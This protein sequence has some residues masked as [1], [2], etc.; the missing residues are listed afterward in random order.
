M[1]ETLD[2]QTSK[3]EDGKVQITVTVPAQTVKQ[4][5]DRHF[6]DLGRARI[7]GFRPGKAPR[8]ILEQNFGGHEAVYG[9]ITTDMIN[10]IA[11]IAVDSQDV[12]FIANPDFDET[13]IVADGEDFTFTLSGKVKP[14]VEL[15]SFDP[16][17]IKMPAEEATAE[18]IDAQVE[19]L[20]TY[21][22]SFETIEDRAVAAGDFVMLNMACTAEDKPV[23]GLNSESRLVELGAGIIPAAME[24]QII[25]MSTGDSKSFDF[26]IEGDEDFAYL[27]VSA[28]HADIAVKE[29]RTKIVPEL[30]A[31]FAEKLGVES[32]DALREQLAEAINKQKAEQLPG[33]K[34]ERCTK[35]LAERVF[36]EV[37]VDYVTFTRQDILRDFYINLQQQGVT[38]DQFF[39]QQGIT[40]DEF[41]KDLDEEA[42]EVAAQTL[43]LDALYK[44]LELEITDEDIDKEFQVVDDPAAVRKQ[45]EDNGRMSELREAIRRRKATEWLIENA[46]VTLDEGDADEDEN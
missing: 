21:Y 28:I 38:L 13:G 33:L 19:A 2:I 7:P 35:A 8:K 27:G 15:L 45:W 3:L 42:K 6:K 46:V 14:E 39:A 40:A 10:E 26:S 11:P 23:Q 41:N 29:I 44:H 18:E 17:Q 37:P 9:E 43:A 22:Y 32:I 31:E 12:L 25:G 36:G 1:E 30:D 4:H 34:E 16:V 24:E 5:I 20:R